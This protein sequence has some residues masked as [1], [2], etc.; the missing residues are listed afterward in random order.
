MFFINECI[1]VA[2]LSC[3]G[4]NSS[5]IPSSLVMIFVLMRK[6]YVFDLAFQ[7][8]IC[9]GIFVPL[10]NFLLLWRHHNYRWKAANF[11]LCSTL[12]AAGQFWFFT[13]VCYTYYD[14]G[15]PFIVVICEEQW[16]SQLLPSVWQYLP[17][18]PVLTT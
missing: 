18:L 6:Y 4:K 10:E 9:L 8:F 12:R 16:Q 5:Y 17:S 11:D 15:H 1:D 13:L 2:V 14:T 7:L 3:H